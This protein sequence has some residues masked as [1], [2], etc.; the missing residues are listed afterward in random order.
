M[1]TQGWGAIDKLSKAGDSATGTIAFEGSPPMQVPAGAAGDVLTSDGDGN[2]TL[3]APTGAGSYV[4]LSDLPISAANGGTGRSSL[5]ADELLAGNGTGAVQSLAAGTSGQVLTSN[6]PG[7]LPSFATPSAGFS[8]PMTTTGDMIYEN[9]SSAAAPLHIGTSGQVLTV[10]AGLPAW[11]NAASGFSNPMTTPG[12]LLYEN[13][14]SV[15][16][17]LPVGTSGE[18]LTVVSGEPAWAAPSGGGSGISVSG[19]QAAGEVPVATSSSAVS[20]NGVFGTRPEWFGTI[21][22]SSG[23]E[24]A[25]NA[26]IAAVVARR[27]GCP[28]PVVITQACGVSNTVTAQPGVNFYGTGQGNRQVF[29]DTFAGGCI[30]PSS[31]FPAS[32]AL[33]TIGTA[34]DP[35]TNPC[36]IR[37]DGICL[38]GVLAGG[39]NATGCIGILA[40]DTADVHLIGCYFA[41]FD[42]TGATGYAI[43]AAS[44]SAGNG[45]GLN[46]QN[47]VISSSWR[48]LYTTGAGLTDL[49]LSGNLWHSNTEQVT[50]GASNL[51]GGGCQMTNDHLTY[52]TMASTGWHLQLGS[53]AGDFAFSNNYFDQ[54][55]SAVPVQLATAK[56]LLSNNQFLA[57]ASSTAV[58]LVKLSTS[59]QELS[60][61]GNNCNGNG[62]S[63]TSLFQTSAHS[64]APTGG[65]YLG[66]SVYGGAPDLIA[67]L[68]DST[69][70]PIAAASTSSLYVAGNCVFS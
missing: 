61:C 64:G 58:S 41:N 11:E 25:I 8:D 14:S 6:G 35:T 70:T 36:G 63:I 55:G 44:A 12:D 18:V 28:G 51:G 15:A 29:P 66:N 40:T 60:F 69:S 3:Q 22:G 27:P 53:Q 34:G 23:D 4:P 65:I 49:R 39:G 10:S 19:T 2:I 37:L 33:I 21:S 20:W 38:S 32:T 67:V 24:V 52:S 9:S 31:S 59:S 62:S 46:I 17:R 50:I 57:A 13:G 56:G 54:A 1:T 42:R 7:T 48:G 43:S 26:A 68:I 47:C 5:T 45:V 30:F 16:A